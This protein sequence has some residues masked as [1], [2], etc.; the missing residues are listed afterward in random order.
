[1]TF[2]FE[3]VLNGFATLGQLIMIG[4]LIVILIEWAW[5]SIDEALDRRKQ[6][7]RRKK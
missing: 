6:K 1:M 2:T 4:I 3:Q 5:S 7:K